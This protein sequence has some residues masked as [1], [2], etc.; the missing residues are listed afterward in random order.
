MIYT[1]HHP[2][3]SYLLR[4]WRGGED[5]SPVLRILLINPHT[6]QVRSFQSLSEM[7]D[8]LEQELNRAAGGD[9]PSPGNA[10]L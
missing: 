4:L 5:V 3:L 8:F 6:G 10:G 9:Q 2:T 7:V 1:N